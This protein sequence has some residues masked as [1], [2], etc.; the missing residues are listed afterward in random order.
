MQIVT[1][2]LAERGARIVTG[3]D[4]PFCHVMPGFGLV[5]ELALLVDCGMQPTAC[6]RAAT[7]DAAAALQMEDRIGSVEAG[8]EADLIVVRGDPSRDIR[9]L[10]DIELVI[11]GG[12]RLEP[13]ALLDA[14][15]A[16]RTPR[17][18]RRFSDDY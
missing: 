16:D 9:A 8:H 14:A 10:R 6:L 5:D 4:A 11:R 15:R 12:T 18:P 17:P 2:S 3:S 13:R 7:R 1:A